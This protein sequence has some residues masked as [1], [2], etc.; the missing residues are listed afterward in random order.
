MA[1][2][3]STKPKITGEEQTGGQVPR[4]ISLGSIMRWGDA[5]KMLVNPMPA[6]YDTYRD[7]EKDPTL[8]LALNLAIAPITAAEW[9]IEVKDDAPKDAEQF[10]EDQFFPI[11][12][13]FID[14]ALRGCY[15]LGWSP[16]EKIFE[17][18]DGRIELKKL[19]PLLQDITEI[20]IL[21]KTGAFAG[22]KQGKTDL[23]LEN[24]LL[25]NYGVKGTQW[26]GQGLLE[27]ARTT[28]N[29]WRDA[30]EG[31]ARYDRKLAGSH[32]VL[33]YENG[34]SMCDGSMKDNSEIAGMILKAMESSGSVA[35]PVTI[36]GFKGLD[37]LDSNNGSQSWKLEILEDAGGRQPTFIERLA[38]LDKR[39]VRA[40]LLP[41]R[42]VL[43]GQYGTKAE[44]AEHINLAF[45]QAE[46]VH[47]HV[48]RILNW[49]AVD[50]LLALNYG[51]K[52]RG[53]VSLVAMPIVDAKLVTLKEIYLA[54]L[55]NPAG[56]MEESLRI[57]MAGIADAI[58]VPRLSEEEIAAA[59][60]EQ[61]QKE[62]ED[63]EREKERLAAQEAAAAAGNGEENAGNDNGGEPNAPPKGV[64][65]FGKPKEPVAAAMDRAR[66]GSGFVNKLFDNLRP[67]ARR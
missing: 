23:P 63:R 12:E 6:S 51:E 34:Q 40:I 57:D 37:N 50:Q 56:F 19:K 16:F 59:E 42:S 41:E 25:A 5:G 44:A 39:L 45:I 4:G 30:N 64:N 11:R 26:Y 15:T 29:Q 47:R 61:E 48:T 17:A 60:A 10:I 2:K 9:A 22:F 13:P 46:L 58:G 43:E 36:L 14:A 32:F 65:P 67:G 33:Y 55:G 54:F 28:W 7:M 62:Q 20:N 21:E 38:Y 24:A 27:N 18:V 1:E 35:I 49:H 31:A 66:K 8:A 3:E 52:Y 53:T